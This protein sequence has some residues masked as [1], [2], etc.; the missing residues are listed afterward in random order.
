MVGS[1]LVR[2]LEHEGVAELL[3][4][5]RSAL[6]LRDQGAVRRFF[7]HERPDAVFLAAA[8]VGGIVANNTFRWD[9]LADNL[10]IE[11]NVLTAAN[12]VGS[13]R[14][15]FFGSS[16]VYPRLAPQ[17]I[18]EDSLLGGPLEA[19]NEPYAIAKIA[20]VKLVEAANAQ[21]GRR[22]VSLM[23]TNLY[24][25]NDNFDL[26]TSHVLPAMLRKFHDARAASLGAGRPAA[27]VVLWGSGTPRREFL[28]VDD[29]SRAAL[30]VAD[31]E[32]TGLI[33][34]GYGSDVTIA[35][36]ADEVRSAVGYEGEV[37]WDATRP[38]G[39]PR[40]LL[41]SSRIRALGWAPAISLREGLHATYEW[42]LASR[43]HSAAPAAAPATS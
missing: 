40:K 6:D 26:E 9:F 1:A 34:V 14:V 15:V 22:W 13:R 43:A 17:P 20:G 2:A 31:T 27:P 18:A 10:A 37:I 5:A 38:E 12:E 41:D 42:F 35:A 3:T 8:R 24:G 36:L 30:L 28:H 21:F 25:P 16:C 11:L 19:T 23:P 39:T 32:C 29:L 7:R 33:N 4:P